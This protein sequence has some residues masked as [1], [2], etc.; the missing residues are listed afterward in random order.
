MPDRLKELYDLQHDLQATH[1]KDPA[2]FT[3]DEAIEFI[4]WNVLALH[5]ELSEALQ[6]VGWKPWADSNHIHREEYIGEL[7]DALHFLFNLFLAVGATPADIYYGYKK[8]N[9][10]NR[11]RQLDGYTGEKDHNG[12]EID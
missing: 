12:R 7:V 10:K 4:R 11:K 1:F 6:E 2:T 5:D 3:R 9:E 8:K